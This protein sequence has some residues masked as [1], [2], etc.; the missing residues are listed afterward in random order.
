MHPMNIEPLAFTID[1]F[2]A[3][4]GIG[5]S[6]AYELISSGRLQAIKLGKRTLIRFE[7]ARRFVDSLPPAEQLKEPA[8]LA[9]TREDRKSAK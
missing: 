5:R 1:R 7:E 9:K 4:T 2:C 6:K 3:F 8:S